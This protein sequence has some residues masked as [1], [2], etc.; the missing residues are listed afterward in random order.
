MKLKFSQFRK[1]ALIVT[2]VSAAGL[3]IVFGLH[4]IVLSFFLAYLLGSL[5]INFI[6]RRYLRGITKIIL[7]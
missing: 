5:C 7:K 2:A 3:A 4:A 6:D 1:S